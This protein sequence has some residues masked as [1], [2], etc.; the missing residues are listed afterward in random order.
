MPEDLER[1]FPSV[2]SKRDVDPAR[3]SFDDP[4]VQRELNEAKPPHSAERALDNFV[5]EQVAEYALS[6]PYATPQELAAAEAGTRTTVE[7]LLH[8][9]N[10][11]ATDE[12]VSTDNA[13]AMR[14][15]QEVV[16]VAEEVGEVATGQEVEPR[17]SQAEGNTSLEDRVIEDTNGFRYRMVRDSKTGNLQKQRIEELP[18]FGT[19]PEQADMIARAQE[20]L[21]AG[22]FDLDEWLKQ[23]EGSIDSEQDKAIYNTV[24]NLHQKLTSKWRNAREG[25]LPASEKTELRRSGLAALN[26]TRR[27]IEEYFDPSF[28]EGLVAHNFQGNRKMLK[29]LFGRLATF[30][31]YQEPT[32]NEGT[33]ETIWRTAQSDIYNDPHKAIDCLTHAY[34]EASKDPDDPKAI[35]YGVVALEILQSLR[36]NLNIKVPETK[37]AEFEQIIATLQG[38]ER[39]LS[40]FS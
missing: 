21:G 14:H 11:T 23:H 13:E 7:M 30:S 16:E 1:E 27:V 3:A 22:E 24:K 6:H 19:S 26:I 28:V 29:E 20:N 35:A 8:A 5:R 31:K 32:I 39:A 36:G 38:N 18:N 34:R 9:P 4:A 25:K 12:Q 33:G 37:K 10:L 2:S 17:P 15:N 40:Q